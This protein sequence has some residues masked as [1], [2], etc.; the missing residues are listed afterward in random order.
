MRALIQRVL[1]AEVSVGG[2]PVGRIDHGLLVYVGVGVDDTAADAAKLA[3]KVAHVRIF[4][5]ADEKMNLSV[6]DVGGALLVV[7]NFTLMADARKG[8]RP[9]FV[10]AARGAEAEALFD[11]F[12]DQ[13][14]RLGCTVATGSFG[15]DM[16][17]RSDADGPVNVLID[18]P[19]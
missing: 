7:P 4:E 12:V 10:A 18:I 14:R 2:E 1:S 16:L 5:D 19:G 6:S 17:I 13:L 15:D 11:A 8:R 3:G 9:A